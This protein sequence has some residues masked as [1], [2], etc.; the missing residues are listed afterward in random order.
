MAERE[1]VSVLSWHLTTLFT[2]LKYTLFTGT[3][4]GLSVSPQFLLH[5]LILFMPLQRIKAIFQNSNPHGS[6]T[7]KT[8]NS[9]V[10]LVMVHFMYPLSDSILL[11]SVVLNHLL[12]LCS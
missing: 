5:L 7:Q 12:S 6:S 11:A 4:Q 8:R 3:A 9:Y 1:V 10:P 2:L